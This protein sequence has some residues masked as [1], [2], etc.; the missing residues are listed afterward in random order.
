MSG[1][2]GIFLIHFHKGSIKRSPT[3]KNAQWGRDSLFNFPNGIGQTGY[4][5][6]QE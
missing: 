2:L 3:A 1:G 6:A 5:Q 4:P